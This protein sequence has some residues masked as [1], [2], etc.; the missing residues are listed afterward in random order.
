MK[1]LTHKR[2]YAMATVC[3]LLSSCESGLGEHV[4]FDGARLD[5]ATRQSRGETSQ[6]VFV[7]PGE[8]LPAASLQV[9]VLVS[10]EHTTGAALSTW[11]MDV[12]HASPTSQIYETSS[13]DEVCRVGMTSRPSRIFVAIHT[14]RTVNGAG[15]CAEA[16]EQLDEEAVTSCLARGDDCWKEQCQQRSTSWR[17]SLEDLVWNSNGRL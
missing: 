14:C 11:V 4:A 12:Y 1:G 16:D 9:G 8:T 5:R 13:E 3:V 7:R 17:A 15:V 2:R 6:V 10:R